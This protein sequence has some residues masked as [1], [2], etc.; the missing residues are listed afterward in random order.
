MSVGWNPTTSSALFLDGKTFAEEERIIAL[1]I[2]L[3]GEKVILV[4]WFIS[5]LTYFFP[6]KRRVV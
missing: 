4:H 6:V 5:S 3:S 1:G 2:T